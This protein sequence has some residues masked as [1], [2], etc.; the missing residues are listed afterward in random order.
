MRTRLFT[1]LLAATLT[2]GAAGAARAHATPPVVY[3]SDREAIVEMTA[4]ASEH[5]V[6]EV[7]LTPEEKRA[8]ASRWNWTPDETSYRFYLGRDENG[9]LVSAVTFLTE[10]TT[11]GPMRAAVALGRDG[12]VKDARIVEVAEE[13][14]AWV[15]PLV[16]NGFLRRFVGLDTRADFTAEAT[17]ETARESMV[18]FYREA[19]ARL[20]ERAAILFDVAFIERGE[21]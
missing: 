15:R 1:L 19:A 16:T 5:F 18:Q 9:R 21:M 10:Y 13:M 3:L 4:G 11:H 20:V 8:I 12:E 6:R 2:A 7:T 14:S 17:Q